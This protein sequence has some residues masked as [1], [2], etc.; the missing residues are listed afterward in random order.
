M[1]AAAPPEAELRAFAQIAARL[2]VDP[3]A[4]AGGS[5]ALRRRAGSG[6]EYLDHRDHVDGDERRSIDWR[7]SAR[8]GRLIVRRTQADAAS[9]WFVCLD[10]SSSMAAAEGGKWRFATCCAAA[11]SYALLDLG[12][13]VGLLVFAGELLAACPAGRG[14]TQF[15]RLMR[16]L[17][18]RRPEP[19]GAASRLVSCLPAVQGAASAFV[20]SDFL[21][22][23]LLRRDLG[24]LSRRCVETHAVQILSRRELELPDLDHLLLVDSESGERLDWQP[25]ERDAAPAAAAAMT[26]ELLAFCAAS[27]I[28][29]SS[30]DTAT[31]WRAALA[32]HLGRARAP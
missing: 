6:L 15:P 3:P 22:P 16:T 2:L 18:A 21:A 11:L 19:S 8:W 7:Q 27:R 4:R 28:R 23:G 5:R 14:A 17:G 32:G 10:A 24:A 30:W 12:H 9:D 13:R 25:T 20:L 31:G 1:N 29:F 26:R